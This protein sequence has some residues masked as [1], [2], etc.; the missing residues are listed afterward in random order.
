AHAR[1]PGREGRRRSRSGRRGAVGDR[2][3]IAGNSCA[4]GEAARMTIVEWVKDAVL[5]LARV[6][7][8]PHVPEGAE[9]SVRVFNAGRNYFTWRMIVWGLGNAATALGLAAAFAF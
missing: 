7:A 9:E 2:R 5:R 1:H 3:R 6:P 4:G 8:D